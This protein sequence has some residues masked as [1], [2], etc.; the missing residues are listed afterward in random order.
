MKNLGK[1]PKI[2]L[3]SVLG[4]M[5]I[6][7]IFVIIYSFNESS[8]SAIWGG[9]SLKWYQTL[10]K[11]QALFSALQNSLIL[12]FSSS[13][14]AAIIGTLGAF[15]M[16][17]V[18]LKSAGMIE[19][20]S[21]LPIMIPEI[22]LGVVFMT[23]FALIGLPFGMTT[24]IIAH[25][26]FCIPYVFML[27][28]ARLI[29]MDK[30]LSEAALDLGASPVRVFFDIILPLIAPAIASGMLLSFTMSLDDVIIS[31]FVTGAKTNTLPLLIY[32]QIKTGITPEINALCT[33]IF[34]ISVVFF[35]IS[36]WIGRSPQ[37]KHLP[38][39]L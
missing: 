11:N 5:Y 19:Y 7:I 8:I 18:K 34:L 27:V 36:L 31:V 29:G 37:K 33:L 38:N 1:S 17:K 30:S 6:P 15:G 12:A 10:F 25:T 21:T 22:I 14:C 4:I 20:I 24:L 26:A 3:G 28:K 23:F 16:T 35:A 32:T 2:F 39:N 13:I 9:F